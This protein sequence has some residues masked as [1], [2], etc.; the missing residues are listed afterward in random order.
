MRRLSRRTLL[1]WAGL[2]VA[3][4]ACISPTLPLPPPSAPDGS[5]LGDG[6]FRLVGSLPIYG[7]VLVRNER[8]QLVVGKGSVTAYDL[9]V[10]A[11]KG[12]T[13]MLWYET[14]VGD[15]SSPIEFQIDRLTPIIGDN[16]GVDGG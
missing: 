6:T 11:S 15:I 13:M 3:I 12:D 5:D 7:T 9:V 8:T 14:D 4:P 1:A 2:G 10:A 16:T